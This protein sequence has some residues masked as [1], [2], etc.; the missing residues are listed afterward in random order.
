VAG[1]GDDFFA[2]VL[3]RESNPLR[4]FLGGMPQVGSRTPDPLG[5]GL[6]EFGLFGTARD[7]MAQGVMR[8]PAP[9]TFVESRLGPPTSAAPKPASPAS[10]GPLG[11]AIAA[12]TPAPA[13]TGESDLRVDTA[14]PY[15][16]LAV[17][18][19]SEEGVDPTIFTRLIAQE[20]RYN[21]NATSRMGAAGLTQLMPETA[22]SLGVT[23]PYDPVQN[24]RGGARYLRQMLDR[25]GGDY[26]KALAAYNAGPKNVD[27]YGGVPPFSETQEYVRRIQGVRAQEPETAR[28]AA[29]A[30]YEVPAPPPGVRPLK[31]ITTDQY[32][33]ESLATGAADY[34]CGPIAAQAFAR[35]NGRN[36]T[37]QEALDLARQLGV[38][39][40]EGGMKGAD[41][42]VTLIRRLGGV[43]TKGAVAKDQIIAELQAGRPVI[44]DTDAGSRGHYFVIEGYDAATDRFDFGASARALRAS[45]GNSMYRLD[46]IASL[47]FGAPNVAIYA[48]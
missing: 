14:S 36:P 13:A 6:P 5:F 37:L 11:R 40:A 10:L 45:R 15:F 34:I 30:P 47:G 33:S 29:S 18:V 41:S 2:S 20:S 31:G 3:G 44:I 17:Q 4:E 48:R 27:D 8:F 16:N 24:L 22:R 26:T 7:P 21:P 23:D 1:F 38:I 25:Y 19:A 39:T 9:Q 35:A 28:T 12:R 46:E 32:G 42:T 43:A